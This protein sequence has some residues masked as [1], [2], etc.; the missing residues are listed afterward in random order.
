MKITGFLAAILHQAIKS[1]VHAN[2]LGH[3]N[4]HLLAGRS[5][6]WIVML[7]RRRPLTA[8]EPLDFIRRVT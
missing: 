4:T 1:L 8:A 6:V 3:R 2:K 5:V 7:M